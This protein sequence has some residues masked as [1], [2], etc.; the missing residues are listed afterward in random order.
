MSTQTPLY[1]SLTTRP[2]QTS[3]ISWK[4]RL[5]TVQA[6]LRRWQRRLITRRQLKQL[7]AH[8]Y[9]DIGL[10]PHEV[11]REMKRHFWR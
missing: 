3:R 1:N 7:P 8:L 4:G 5:A 9:R 2:T 10:L 11:Q 6:L